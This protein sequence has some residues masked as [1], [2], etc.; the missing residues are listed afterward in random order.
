MFA[1]QHQRDRNP[2][3][4]VL[5]TKKKK[6]KHK[7]ESFHYKKM[8]SSIPTASP[9]TLQRA[10]NLVNVETHDVMKGRTT[11]WR[12]ESMIPPSHDLQSVDGTV[13]DPAP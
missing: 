1:I 8:P 3:I 4:I 10:Q 11:K 12:G 7:S 2:L 13:L 6:K 5:N 9:I